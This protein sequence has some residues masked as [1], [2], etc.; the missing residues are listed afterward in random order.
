MNDIEVAKQVAKDAGKQIAELRAKVAKDKDV[1]ISILKDCLNDLRLQN[2]FIK[3]IV[4]WL[5]SIIIL[6]ILI[7]ASQAIYSQERLVRFLSEY[8]YSIETINDADNNS[9]NSN[10]INVERK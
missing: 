2:R 1:H 5:C 10:N 6:L 7:V 8:D 9:T 3:K 4:W